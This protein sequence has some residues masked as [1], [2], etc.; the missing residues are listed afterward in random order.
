[1]NTFLVGEIQCL[2]YFPLPA[3]L[4]MQLKMPSL[5]VKLDVRGGI[6]C[7]L[8]VQAQYEMHVA[9]MEALRAGMPPVYV[10]HSNVSGSTIRDI[11]MQN[12]SVTVGGRD[13]IQ[14]QT[15]TLAFGRHYGESI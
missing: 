11:H 8:L 3:E 10:N 6:T 14:D 2:A 15:L 7:S 9:E 4:Y 5:L 1:M 13:L 12:F